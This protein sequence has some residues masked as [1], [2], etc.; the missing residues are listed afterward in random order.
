[1]GLLHGREGFDDDDIAAES[2]RHVI[3]IWLRDTERQWKLPPPLQ[4]TWARIFDDIERPRR[5]DVEP[6]IENGEWQ[7]RGHRSECA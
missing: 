2:R 4:L 6:V 3:R 5:W 7:G 1:M